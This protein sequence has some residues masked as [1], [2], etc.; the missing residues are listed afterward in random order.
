MGLLLLSFVDSPR[1]GGSGS[2][3]TSPHTQSGPP[4][5]NF[6]PGPRTDS[7]GKLRHAT[8]LPPVR[9]PVTPSTASRKPPLSSGVLNELQSNIGNEA[10]GKGWVVWEGQLASKG[11]TM[12]DVELV[13]YGSAVRPACM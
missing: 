7:E 1:I 4:R 10:E 12:C 2:Q 8:P 13:T 9:S 11:T 3:W 6:T 5:L